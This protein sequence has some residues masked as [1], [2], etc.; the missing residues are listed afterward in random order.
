MHMQSV[1]N[2]LLSRFIIVSQDIHF[3]KSHKVLKTVEL[4]TKCATQTEQ[5]YFKDTNI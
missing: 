2:R 5:Y 4:L 3:T 1:G